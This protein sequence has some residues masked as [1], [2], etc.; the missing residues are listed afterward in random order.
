V[1]NEREL[2]AAWVELIR[3]DEKRRRMGE[4]AKAL[5][6]ANRGATAKSLERIAEI[7]DAHRSGE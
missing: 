7:L 2:G 6:E 1:A 5:V 4:S 3:G